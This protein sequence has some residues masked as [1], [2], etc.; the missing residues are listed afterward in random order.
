ME[1]GTWAT[2]GAGNTPAPSLGTGRVKTPSAGV[3]CTVEADCSVEATSGVTALPPAAA[4][5]CKSAAGIGV[6]GAEA[7]DT[8]RSVLVAAGSVRDVP[9]APDVVLRLLGPEVAVGELLEVAADMLDVVGTLAEL[10]VSV[11]ATSEVMTPVCA[12]SVVVTG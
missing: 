12:T 11:D 4:A 2:E 3:Y 10:P 9:A 6:S 8:A 1:A 7:P 5:N